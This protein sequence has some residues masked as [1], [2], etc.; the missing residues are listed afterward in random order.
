MSETLRAADRAA[1]AIRGKTGEER[2]EAIS[3]FLRAA[4]VFL[5][6]G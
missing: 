3:A 5:L 4:M 1:Q 6:V 2:R